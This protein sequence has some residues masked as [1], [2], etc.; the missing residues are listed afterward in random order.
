MRQSPPPTLGMLR[1]TRDAIKSDARGF[2]V[3]P[4]SKPSAEALSVHNTINGTVKRLASFLS[5]T[6]ES[7]DIAALSM[8]DFT[9]GT[10]LSDT[11]KSRGVDRRLKEINYM[12]LA[13]QRFPVIPGLDTTWLKFL[14]TLDGAV[15]TSVNL[16]DDFLLPFKQLLANAINDPESLSSASLRQRSIR[17][18]FDAVL[19]A[20]GKDL[21]GNTRIPVRTWGRLVDRN[22]DFDEVVGITTTLSMKMEKNNMALVK[23][24]VE[25]I[26][27][28]LKTL[29][30]KLVD[31]SEPYRPSKALII[32]LS[33]MTFQLA[34]AVQF[35]GITK[36]NLMLHEKSIAETINRLI[37]IV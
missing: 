6:A 14:K 27:D 10:T 33:D 31:P 37:K 25:E 15:E 19:K 21:S 5:R 16:Y 35:Y 24:T 23:K 13:P 11:V 32:E 9:F 18:D 26:N 12:D 34:A 22:T 29:S 4:V 30:T 20:M 7:I 3:Q 36:N 28:L 17:Y 2:Y 8:V 1:V